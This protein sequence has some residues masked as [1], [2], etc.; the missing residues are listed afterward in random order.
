M[1]DPNSK[2]CFAPENISFYDLKSA[3]M[4]FLLFKKKNVAQHC[5]LV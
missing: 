5:A 2:S 3:N 1:F 4:D